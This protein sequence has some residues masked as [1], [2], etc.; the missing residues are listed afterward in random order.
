MK[1]KENTP[2]NS[3]PAW[4]KELAESDQLF[5]ALN[6]KILMVYAADWV[7]RY[8]KIAE[9]YFNTDEK[10]SNIINSICLYEYSPEYLEA[11]EKAPRGG[12]LPSKYAVVFETTDLDLSNKKIKSVF[13]ELK[14]DTGSIFTGFEKQKL[15]V[16]Y[17]TLSGEQPY[18][19]FMN[20]NFE[21]VYK[22]SPSGDW[23]LE[24]RFFLKTRGISPPEGVRYDMPKWTLFP[25]AKL[26]YDDFEKK[27]KELRFS[28]ET[29]S[30][31]KIREK[32]GRTA[33][34][35]G[36]K[37]L[38]FFNTGKAW[39]DFI[40][41]IKKPPHQYSVGASDTYNPVFSEAPAEIKDK[42]KRET[43]KDY[44]KEKIK[45]YNRRQK[46]LREIDNKLKTF[47]S[48]PPY[49]WNIPEKYKFYELSKG[50]GTG[51]YQFKFE[52]AVD[53]KDKKPSDG[54]NKKASIKNIE[55]LLKELKHTPEEL[56]AYSI[57][58]CGIVNAVKTALDKDYMS[59]DEAE[60]IYN[61]MV[62]LI[63]PLKVN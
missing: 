45:R 20:N 43:T 15:K 33:E 58:E 31:I 8:F 12:E 57:V 2:Q 61:K 54:L 18:R 36:Y 62:E 32:P 30:D 21:R 11:L 51:L 14:S 3:T 34:T 41:I 37:K 47:F 13:E 40:I 35:F 25:H 52:C 28:Y 9:K 48:L 6:K 38:G 60:K 44:I 26:S 5:P 55:K 27:V 23:H 53:I 16:L 19:N 59:K 10:D 56:P 4:P 1:E 24:W 50:K 49:E 7:E 39:K 63:P 17:N 29:D 42:H 22:S 46:R